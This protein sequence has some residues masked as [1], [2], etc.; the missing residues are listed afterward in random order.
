MS[1]F[2]NVL[3]EGAYEIT[4]HGFADEEY[5]T[6]DTTGWNALV[7]VSAVTLLNVGA[8]DLSERFR[9]EYGDD[10]LYAWIRENNE[11][12]V[13]LVEHTNEDRQ[14]LTSGADSINRA[15]DKYTAEMDKAAEEEEISGLID[16]NPWQL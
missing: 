16:G 9:Q 12:F 5:G 7:T 11:G 15:F 8:N 14:G 6:A 4:L 13:T 2:D 10:T 1:K 3:A